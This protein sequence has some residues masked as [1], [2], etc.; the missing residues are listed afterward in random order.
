MNPAAERSTIPSLIRHIVKHIHPDM[1]SFMSHK[2]ND[3]WV[4]I[5]YKQALEKIDAISAWFLEIGIKK[6]DRLALIIENGPDYI[7][8]DQALQQI[9]AI[10]T[11]IYPTL[12]EA[13]IEYILND[14]AAR[15]ILVGNSFL[16]R[17][18]IK[19]ANNCPALIRI[20]PA[21]ADIDKIIANQSLNAGVISFKQVIQE[22]LILVEKHSPAINIAR[23]AILP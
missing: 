3:S 7:Y 8:Y 15:T 6:G 17:K 10:N 13:E 9:G 1:H 21:F 19:V 11:S 23:E 20:I 18:V 22:G 4:D 5:S 14:S 2:V 16:M 12:T